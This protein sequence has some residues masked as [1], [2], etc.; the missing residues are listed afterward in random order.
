MSRFRLY[1]LYSLF[2]NFRV[3]HILSISFLKHWLSNPANV[4]ALAPSSRYLA[5]AMAEDVRS[6]D[7]IVEVGAGTGAITEVIVRKHPQARLVLF[8][9]AGSLAAE[10]A[11]RYPRAEVIAGPFHE[12]AN[13]LEGLPERTIFVSALPFRSLPASVIALTVET[14]AQ[15]LRV[16]PVRKLVQFTYQPRAPFT[17]PDGFFWRR[18][19]T[20]WR[21]APPA[22][23]WQ[24]IQV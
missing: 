16:A 4:G 21:N 13:V 18:S 15:S 10:L 22:S 3:C 14:L 7:A 1:M 19:R 9:L 24:L 23:V 5:D 6:F 2:K 20:I 11:Q 17:P 12:N 8:E